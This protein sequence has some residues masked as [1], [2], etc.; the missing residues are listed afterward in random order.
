M[1][2][3]VKE[4]KK[5]KEN[6]IKTLKGVMSTYNDLTYK[7]GHKTL[8]ISKIENEKEDLI[9]QYIETAEKEQQIMKELQEK[10]GKGT[11]DLES[12]EVTPSNTK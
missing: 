1:D 8:I 2:E 3:T 7:I 12:W 4:T 6:E 10:Y 11:I 5:L 9:N